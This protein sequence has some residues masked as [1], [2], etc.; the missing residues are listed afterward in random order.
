METSKNNYSAYQIVTQE[1][2]HRI[3]QFIRN[4]WLFLINSYFE[5]AHIYIFQKYKFISHAQKNKSQLQKKNLGPKEY[6]L[7]VIIES[8]AYAEKGI[9]VLSS[10]QGPDLALYLGI[11]RCIS[12]DAFKQSHYPASNPYLK[13]I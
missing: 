4:Q 13:F 1:T 12:F 5:I 10:K 8:N 3:L 2:L 7:F 9:Y 11:S 6:S